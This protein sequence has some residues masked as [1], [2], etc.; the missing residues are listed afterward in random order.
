VSPSPVRSPLGAVH[1]LSRA[2]LDARTP[3]DVTSAL[4]VALRDGLGLGQVHLSEV[5]QGGEVGRA[6]VAADAEPGLTRYVQVLDERP[7]GVARVVASGEPLI[8]PDARSAQGVRRDLVERFNVAS[9]AY[10]PLSWGGD[11]RYVAILISHEPREF[12]A[13]AVAFA[14]TLAHHAAAALALLESEQRRAARAERDAALT[15]AAI[16]LGSSLELVEVLET[17]AREADLALGGAL[18]GVYLAD[19]SGGG[20][21]TAGHNCPPGWAGIVLSRGEGVAGR[22][23]T[24]GEPFVTNAYQT[25]IETAHEALGGIQ[26]AAGVPM[27]WNGELKGALSV[28]FTEMRR[29]T[30]EDL[31]TLEAIAAFAIVACRNAEA[32]QQARVA[33]ATDSLTGLSN[34][35]ALHLRAREEI[36]RARRSGTP[37]ACLLL[38][39]DDFKTVNDERGHQAGDEQLRA[40]AAS[41]RAALRDHDVVA[42]YGGDEFVVLLPHADAAAGR[43]VAERIAA[44]SPVRCS[45][46][47]AQWGE[48]LSAG[49]LLDR[50]D[51]ALLL[52]KR[53]GKERVAVAGADLEQEL[54]LVEARAG[55][56]EAIMREFW[57]MVAASES[58]RDTLLRL[59]S[60]LRRS[61]GAEEVA[62]FELEG[63]DALVRAAVARQPEGPQ[64][65]AFGAERVHATGALRERLALGAI[66]RPSLAGLLAAIGAEDIPEARSAP[67]GVY[68][69]VPLLWAGRPHGLVAVRTRR[70]LSTE[71]LR[72]LEVLA[73][74]TMAVYSAQPDSGSP[75][76]VQALAAAIEARDDYT[77]D[78]SEQVV[79]LA[80]DVAR[81]LGLSPADLDAVRHGA[82]LHDVGKLAIPNEILH[83][84]GPLTDAEWRVMAEHPVIG[85]RI[86]RR[87]PQLGHLAP[88]VRHEH[89]RWDGS[90]YPDGLAGTE[91]PI[92]SRIILACDAYNAMITTRPYRDAMSPADAV[93]ELRDKSGTQF[94]PQVVAALLKRLRAPALSPSAS[95]ASAS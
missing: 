80:T 45:I 69:A 31:R 87:T 3:A 35:G 42:R 61:I 86:L 93:A 4:V 67:A 8:V 10:V 13:E 43:R 55:S 83:K 71:R 23:L 15:R 54:E 20:V 5:S 64:E 52:A 77:H 22:V 41:L 49:E 68:A 46:G 47:V 30:E 19:G 56:T 94:D 28:G 70:E 74:Q 37:L 78:H 18:A 44:A 9:I 51:R 82:L 59:P 53:T 21:A 91:I 48:P 60:F 32:Y 75:A 39:L 25:E 88:I 50:A 62:V 7:S 33:A 84:P 24:T 6:T 65:P 27:A 26:T 57:E 34:H 40:V 76:A 38:D 92:A 79:S 66:S 72:L 90:G 63:D 85:E 11:V 16:A 89:E 58:S 95:A 36:S 1:R 81:L 2:V 17:L 73:R 14:E 29:L 12:D